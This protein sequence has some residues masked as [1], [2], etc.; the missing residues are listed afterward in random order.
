M[1]PQP[2]VRQYAQARNITP[3]AFEHGIFPGNH[4]GRA[5]FRSQSLQD[6]NKF[7]GLSR[8]N[9]EILHNHQTLFLGLLAEDGFEG[10]PLEFLRDLV[11]VVPG[12]G[13]E[14]YSTTDPNRGLPGSCPGPAR[15]FLAP[16][17]GAA[18]ANL[19]PGL[20]GRRTDSQI[21]QLV[22]DG[23]IDRSRTDGS[24]EYFVGKIDVPLFRSIDAINLHNH[25]ILYFFFAFATSSVL[26]LGPGTA[27]FTSSTPA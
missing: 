25:G 27:P 19:A 26:P 15:S 7:P 6:F 13:A 2:V 24:V 22:A 1:R 11:T 17:F 18:A 5:V 4:D 14:G 16:R 20:G 8:F 9:R 3:G 10:E 12:F 21:G 23:M